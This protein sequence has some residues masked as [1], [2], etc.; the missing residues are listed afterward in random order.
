M[1]IPPTSDLEERYLI[2]DAKGNEVADMIRWA[3]A[4][5]IVALINKEVP[6]A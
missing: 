6:T 1:R 3:D 2:V 4:N 5:R